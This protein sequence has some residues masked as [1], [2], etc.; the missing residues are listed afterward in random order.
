M[1]RFS[2]VIDDLSDSDE[3][4]VPPQPPPPTKPAEKKKVA[5]PTIRVDAL[6]DSDEDMDDDEE[7]EEEGSEEE[8]E[9]E[10]EEDEDEQHGS[11]LMVDDELRYSPHDSL[12]RKA[13]HKDDNMTIDELATS[14]KDPEPIPTPITPWAMSV[15]VDPRKMVVMQA[16]LFRA[17][18]EQE[19][20]KR[21][22][23]TLR[24]AKLL[25]GVPMVTDKRATPGPSTRP[26]V[27]SL[28]HRH[29]C[30]ANPGSIGKNR[31]GGRSSLSCRSQSAQ[32]RPCFVEA[33]WQ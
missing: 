17:P 23:E 6:T 8:S 13:A 31:L 16:S 4:V 7:A 15:G 11:S 1:A 18:E 22:N 33:G 14:E 28:V 32:S 29:S 30:L 26:Q 10:D 27:S 21:D 5:R 25:P 19:A 3:E 24:R 2:A 12:S 9:E 20:L